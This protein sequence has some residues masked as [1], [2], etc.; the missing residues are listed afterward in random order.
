MTGA[1]SAVLLANPR[2]G[3]GRRA[4]VT[5]DL[6]RRI[7]AHGFDVEV[8]ATERAGHAIDL[9]RRAARERDVAYVF[10]LG[11]DGTAREA[12]TGLLGTST[13]L[14]PLPGGTTNVVAGALGLGQ[15][16]RRAADRLDD[17]V[18]RDL[19]VGLC[20][21]HP[22]LMQASAGLDATVM[23]NL[24]P[25]WKARLGKLE[26]AW[27][28][29]G[30]WWRYRFPEIRLIADGEALTARGA[31]VAN[32]PM[33]AGQFRLIPDGRADDGKLDLLLFHGSSRTA[34]LSFAAALALGRHDRRRDVEIRRVERVTLEAPAD[35]ALQVDGDVLLA[36][37]PIEIGLSPS[38]LRVLGA[39]AA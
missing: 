38:R 1:R 17:F 22:F 13:V 21:G 12:A 34:A 6:V 14:V 26:V 2:S 16:A 20:D 33:Y 9:A 31:I 24:R 15:D 27:S 29:A 5:D 35:L 25:Q 4:A 11:G 19:D 36:A 28:G 30:T 37:P 7:A 23:R 32:L 39:P 18:V 10:T 8:L 3:R